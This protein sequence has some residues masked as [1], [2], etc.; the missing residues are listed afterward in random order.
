MTKLLPDPSPYPYLSAFFKQFWVQ[1]HLGMPVNL[2][3]IDLASVDN[4]FGVTG[5]SFQRAGMHDNEYLLAEGVK[6][7][8][9]YG[10]RD[11]RYRWRKVEKLALAAYMNGTAEVEAW[12]A[13][14]PASGGRPVGMR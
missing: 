3:T 7:T 2:T 5:N 12:V 4:I 13:V 1:S 8:L 14:K 6:V 9:I 10:D 11:Y